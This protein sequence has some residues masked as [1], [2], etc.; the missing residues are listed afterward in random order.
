MVT[1]DL[2]VESFAHYP[3]QARSFAVENLPILKRMPLILLSV[4]LRQ[5]IQYDW[6]FPAEREQLH[7]QFDLLRRTGAASFEALMTPFFAI[8]LSSDLRRADWIN[9]PQQFSEQLTGYLWSQHEIDSYHKAA[10][11]YYEYLQ[12]ALG[13]RP[14]ATPR[15]TI[16][17]IGQGSQEVK[18]PLFRKLAPH[19]TMFTQLDPADGLKTLMAEVKART[20]QHPLRYGHWYIEGGE[21]QVAAVDTEGLTVM[22]YNRL[23]PVAKREF[24]LLNQFTH[25]AENGGVAGTEAVSSYIA[26]LGPED[27]DLRGT[28]DDAPLRHFEVN[29]LTQGAGCQ[30]FSTTFVQWATRECLH[31]A[32]P[33]TL[34]ARFGTRQTNAPMEQLLTRDPLLQAQDQ[35]GSLID[36]DMGAYYAWINQSRLAG[37]NQSRFLA[38]FEGHGLA[39]AIAPA[40]ARGTT[41]TASAKMDQLLDWMR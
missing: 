28:A 15:W 3:P 14:P 7:L 16:V 22:S 37:A 33:L 8:Q 19:G 29:L 21:P 9:R 18:Q 17:V 23:V 41:S 34:F 30:I 32:E 25:R 6:C 36:A 26:G 20:Q 31:R 27:V 24:A 11:E 2:R 5:I 39:C 12:K 4:V 38:W 1:G 40:L 35:E 13:E 10:Q